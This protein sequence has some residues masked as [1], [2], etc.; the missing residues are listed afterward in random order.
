MR[1]WFCATL[2]AN[3][4][5][6]AL[7]AMGAAPVAARNGLALGLVPDGCQSAVFHAEGLVAAGPVTLF[8]RGELRRR[9]C[10][11]GVGL[12]EDCADGTLLLHLYARYGAAR[13][14][15]VDGM[16]A[17][18]ILDGEELVL[19]R[20]HAGARTLFYARAGGDRAASASL[21]AL[22]AWPRLAARLNLN[23][24]RAF[25]T[26]AYLPGE[27]TLLEDV[28]EA[29]PGRCLRLRAGGVCYEEEFWE[30]RE[31]AWNA[32]DLPESRARGL[33]ALL[34]EA[35]AARLPAGQ[36]VGV[37]LSG[38]ID[39]SLVTALAAR[40]HQ[41]PVRTY[42][43]NFGG[44]LPN[45]LAYSGLVAAH[46]RTA[47]TVLTFEGRRIAE[48]LAMLRRPRAP[49]DA[50]SARRAARRAAAGTARGAVPRIAPYDRLPQPPA[51]HQPP[52][53]GRTTSC[54]RSSV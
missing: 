45:E 6:A 47:H 41:H 2:D 20:D 51:V 22:R 32:D 48:H 16:F 7:A 33:R 17:V 42:A 31:G 14:T 26:F 50:R 25:L 1:G 21:R 24:V 3:G 35:V 28:Y 39:S 52:H 44:D 10:G 11:D 34:E 46:C 38:G 29:R 15:P 36:P 23:A 19:A 43:I 8:N 37:F 13:L 49:A 18:A 12:P 5:E 27:E 30:P 40:L 53:Q 4:A 9:L 54:P